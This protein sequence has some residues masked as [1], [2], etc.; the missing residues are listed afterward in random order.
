MAADRAF[1]KFSAGFSNS[2]GLTKINNE[3]K[4]SVA[5]F[6]LL[7]L[8]FVEWENEYTDVVLDLVQ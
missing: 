4:A 7:V 5:C 3:T 1:A 6:I 8:D 2:L